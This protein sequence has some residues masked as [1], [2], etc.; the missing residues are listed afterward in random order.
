[1]D[2]PQA[3]SRDEWLA[4]LFDGRRQLIVYHFM[5]LRDTDEGCPRCSLVADNIGD[6][7]HLR[8]CDT[9]HRNGH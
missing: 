8:A 1:M 3:V 6:L 4:G 9:T 2:R 7:S 5:R